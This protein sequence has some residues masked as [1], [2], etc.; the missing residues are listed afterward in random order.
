MLYSSN[1]PSTPLL[2]DLSID[3]GSLP[4]VRFSIEP[5]PK[6]GTSVVLMGISNVITVSSQIDTYV[7]CQ[8][9]HI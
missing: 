1:P 3:I 2:L 6:F 5:L 9:L 7:S 8:S 4:V